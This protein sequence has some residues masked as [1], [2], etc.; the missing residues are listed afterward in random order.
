MFV[1][2]HRAPFRALRRCAAGPSAAFHCIAVSGRAS[3]EAIASVA[4]HSR[5]LVRRASAAD[6]TQRTGA[7]RPAE[8]RAELSAE[9]RPRAF[10]GNRRRA[11]SVSVSVSE[12]MRPM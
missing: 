6:K 2:L 1:I 4:F 8:R 12:I 9:R 10:L 11:V 5:K 7:D 3:G